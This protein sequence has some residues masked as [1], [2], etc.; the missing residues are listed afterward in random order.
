M[1]KVTEDDVDLIREAIQKGEIVCLPEHE[2]PDD[3]FPEE[4][5]DPNFW[6]RMRQEEIS[7]RRCKCTLFD[8][9]DSLPHRFPGLLEINDH[10]IF[11]MEEDLPTLDEFYGPD[12]PS[13][14]PRCKCILT[15]VS[16]LERIK[17]KVLT[18]LRPFGMSAAQA[19]NH[20]TDEIA[21]FIH[22]E[23]YHPETPLTVDDWK[24]GNKG[25]KP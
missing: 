17:R 19:L 6:D 10:P 22:N 9:S 3:S 2:P 21:E 13:V 4:I 25:R 11:H 12:R 23:P 14:S 15:P 5:P 7:K 18:G 20:S 1:R 8:P 24:H 16:L